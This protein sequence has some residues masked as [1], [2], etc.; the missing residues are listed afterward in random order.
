MKYGFIYEITNL[1][2]NKKYIGFKVYSKGWKQYM[3]SSRSLKSDIDIFGIDNFKREILEECDTLEEL[4]RREIYHLE[5]NNVLESDVYYNQSIPHPQF[6]RIKGGSHSNKGKTWEE[7]YGPEYAAKKREDL[8]NRIKGKTWEEICDDKHK[9]E[10]RFVK[11]KT[12]KTEETKRKISE[13]RKGIKFSEEH[14][15]N[16]SKARILYLHTKAKQ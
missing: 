14:R 2:N 7:I 11:A 4:Q 16:L 12:K 3:G 5:L 10:K 6:R 1:I 8:R 13:G 15:N 9:V